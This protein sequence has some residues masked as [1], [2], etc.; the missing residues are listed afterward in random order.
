MAA[1]TTLLEHYTANGNAWRGHAN[2]KNRTMRVGVVIRFERA[3][4]WD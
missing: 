3:A 1:A 2:A 4:L